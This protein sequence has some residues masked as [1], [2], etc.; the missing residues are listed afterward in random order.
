MPSF[1]LCA[2]S[3][4]NTNTRV[5]QPLERI[6]CERARTKLFARGIPV[7]GPIFFMQRARELIQE[8]GDSADKAL[9]A[10]CAEGDIKVAVRLVKELGASVS[11]KDGALRTP[12]SQHY[13]GTSQLSAFWWRSLGQT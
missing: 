12:I 6:F 4:P 10:A 13:T 9:F 11:A 8:N 7:Y 3:S 5:R 2:P 1:E